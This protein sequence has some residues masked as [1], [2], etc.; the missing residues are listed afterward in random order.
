MMR[1]SWT[2][3]TST[4]FSAPIFSSA[5]WLADDR[6]TLHDKIS[7]IGSLGCLVLLVPAVVLGTILIRS[8]SFPVLKSG[9]VKCL[10]FAVQPYV[11]LRL[12]GVR[13][14]RSCCCR[15]CC[16]PPGVPP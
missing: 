5:V 2:Q 8:R 14:Y 4:R 3:M 1:G 10:S 7:T 16:L 12:V 9:G 13:G 11:S 15:R 6:C